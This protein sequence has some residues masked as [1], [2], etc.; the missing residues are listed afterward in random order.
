MS[1]KSSVLLLALLVGLG[2]ALA[3]SCPAHA[4]ATITV[5]NID[6][7]GE[8][9]NDPT[10]FTPTGGNPATTL[11]EARLIAFQHAA[12][13]WGSLLTSSVEIKINAKM[14]PLPG[15]A[16]SAVLG[17]AG[18]TNV[19]RSFLNAPFL[20]TWYPQA[21]ANSLAG[22]DLDPGTPDISA[23][24]NSDVDGP[25]VLGGTDWYYGVDRNPGGDVDFVS[26]VLH[27]LGHGLGFQTF[28][29]VS[30]GAK[31]GGFD[32]TYLRHLECHGSVPSSYGAGTDAQ[33]TACSIGD[34][35]L[36]WIGPGTL[37]GAAALPLTAGFP[38]G[39]VQ[40]HAPS[41]L[42]LG[43]SVSHFSIN[44]FPNQLMEPSYTGANHSV[45]LALQLM[46]DIGWNLQPLNGTDI[47]FLLDMTGSTGALAPQW[48]AQIPTIAQEWK[49]F[50]PNARFALAT[51]VDFPFAPYGVAGEWAYRVETTL[52]PN[53]ANLAAALALLT[54][55]F[56]S[57][58]PESQYEAIYQVLTGA[59][60]DLTPPV[61]Y[62]GTGEIPPV[63]LNQQFPM[64]IYHFTFPEV[65]HD[66]DLEP[67]YPFPGA[68]P[69]AGKTLVK[70]T[71]AIRSSQNMFFGLTFI[72]DPALTSGEGQTPPPVW[73]NYVMARMP[74]EITSG[75]L[76]EL[77][78]LTGGAVYNVGN[79]DL[80]K[81]QEAIRDSIKLWSGS[82]QAGDGD[83]D[84]TPDDDDNCP[85]LANPT[86]ADG[87]HDG[88]GDACDNCAAIPNPDQLDSDF[89]GIGNACDAS[90]A[91]CTSSDTA[92]CLN[93]DRYK[94]E[95][96]WQTATGS[97]IGHAVE[98]T[99]DT[100]YFWFFN[101]DNVEVVVK[102][103]DACGVNS[104]YWVFGAGLTDVQVTLRVLDTKSG[105][106]RTYTN[107][108]G[109]AF[110]PLQDTNAFPTCP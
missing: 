85:L 53:P 21:L 76:A 110:K 9:F 74:L 37:A 8:G 47:V 2:G 36:H 16:T 42:A 109:T 49:N 77:A 97:G 81:L 71:L 87:D 50:D 26:V 45:G 84:G 64:V 95:T 86:Q 99:A 32:D 4:V 91:T 107:P 78:A 69:V 72:G 94:V 10:P 62:S 40:M 11:G 90:T 73:P 103:L 41:P 29:N 33:R 102:V 60:R 108:L 7:P 23:T 17:Q 70:N 105:T 68:S 96:E 48:A 93:A 3:A 66:R 1:S 57:D 82:A 12:F 100:G 39:H 13:L 83:L 55:Q 22:A 38:G 6:G 15:N 27:E 56:G 46:Q 20:N 44:A 35:N 31:L 51:H 88:V 80:S 30:N 59:G 106:I 19:F 79:N 34:P 61:N 98:L 92:L 5:I 18:A 25:V 58:E 101:H 63:S 54:Q 75:A 89:D 24:F 43:S 104:R 67:D 52:N 65:F 28:A 14:D